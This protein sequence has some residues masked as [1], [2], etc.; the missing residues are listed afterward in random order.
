MRM[1]RCE[2]L[3]TLVNLL[4]SG[5][6]YTEINYKTRKEYNSAYIRYKRYIKAHG[7]GHV[8]AL[9]TNGQSLRIVNIDKTECI[10]YHDLARYL[11][12][13]KWR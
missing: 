8:F 13:M 6:A 4:E 5:N 11:A 7:L 12:N 2:S 9:T 1:N 10:N 3:D